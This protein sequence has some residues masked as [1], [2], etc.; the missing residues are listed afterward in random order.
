MMLI[1]TKNKLC[2]LFLIFK[3]QKGAFFKIKTGGIADFCQF[4]KQLLVITVMRSSPNICT[5]NSM[6]HDGAAWLSGDWLA[7]AI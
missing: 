7:P 5:I 4:H 2:H 3:E 6:W 1:I